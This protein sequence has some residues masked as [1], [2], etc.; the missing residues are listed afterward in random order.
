MEKA[1]HMKQTP[2]VSV[3]FQHIQIQGICDELKHPLHEQSKAFFRAF[4][5]NYPNA[6]SRYSHMD[7]ER[8]YRITPTKIE[9]WR[10]IDGAPYQEIFDMESGVYQMTQYET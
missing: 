10:Y 7:N 4:A 1:I 2:E 5:D 8:V 3:C 6:A 9:T